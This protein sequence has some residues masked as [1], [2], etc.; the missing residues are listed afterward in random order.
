MDSP[1]CSDEESVSKSRTSHPIFF[2]AISNEDLVLVLGSQNILAIVLSGKQRPLINK[3]F[4]S[5][6]PLVKI[7][8]CV[9]GMFKVFEIFSRARSIFF[10]ASSPME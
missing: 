3:L 6:P 2:A 8:L 1:F 4:D 10:R 9:G 7:I 5:L